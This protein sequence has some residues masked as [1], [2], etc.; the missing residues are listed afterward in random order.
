[1]PHVYVVERSVVDFLQVIIGHLRNCEVAFLTHPL[2][3]LGE[4]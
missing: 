3:D 2:G 4:R 1:M